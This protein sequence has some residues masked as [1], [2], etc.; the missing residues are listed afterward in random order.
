MAEPLLQRLAKVQGLSKLSEPQLR[1]VA[2]EVADAMLG[3][4]FDTAMVIALARRLGLSHQHNLRVVLG[5]TKVGDAVMAKKYNVCLKTW[6]L[7]VKGDPKL[8]ALAEE[9]MAPGRTRPTRRW[10]PSEVEA[11]MRPPKQGE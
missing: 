11:L 6:R 2:A 9:Y 7:W 4:V 10:S 1:E 5:E 8:A 3:E